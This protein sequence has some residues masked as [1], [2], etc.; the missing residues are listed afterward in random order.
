M[1]EFIKSE[2]GKDKVSLEGYLVMYS[3]HVEH[4][5]ISQWCIYVESWITNFSFQVY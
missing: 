1:L 4:K 2:Q 5:K 3:I